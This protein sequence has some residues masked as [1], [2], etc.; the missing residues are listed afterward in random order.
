[1]PVHFQ[2]CFSFRFSLRIQIRNR[3]KT[4]FKKDLNKFD[5]LTRVVHFKLFLD[6]NPDPEQEPDSEP[7]FIT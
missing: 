7:E 2:V 1:M 4:I 6:P 3:V 5:N